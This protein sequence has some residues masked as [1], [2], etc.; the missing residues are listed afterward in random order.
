MSDYPFKLG[1][2]GNSLP[3][4]GN[5]YWSRTTLS[6]IQQSQKNY[7]LLAFKPGL[8]LQASELNELQE[9]QMMENTLYAT[10]Y[11]SWPDTSG[12]GTFIYGPGW[13]G[14]TPLYPTIDV[15]N[16]TK[17]IVG[18]TGA[19]T[20][21][22]IIIRKGWYLVTVKSSNL[23]HW[24]Y[25]NTDYYVTGPTASLSAYY[26]GFSA[27]YET[28]KPA[29]DTSLYDN[30]TGTTIISGSPAGAD[31]IQVKISNPFWT[32]EIN[33]DDFSPMI[34]KTN[35]NS[36]PTYMNNVNVANITNTG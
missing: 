31:R 19:T 7:C 25:L 18:F 13:N 5:P 17:H 8:P 36:R 26:L 6:Q 23:K 11:Y 15:V 24:I 10:M 32:S 29:D 12:L 16:T 33:S 35:T 3:L 22:N 2:T 14:T 30:S 9:I 20:D 1:V 27:S 4:S 21:G 28:I 34:K